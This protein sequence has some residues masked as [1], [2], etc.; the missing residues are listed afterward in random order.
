[1]RA[2]RYFSVKKDA[3]CEREEA[4]P[5]YSSSRTCQSRIVPYAAPRFSHAAQTAVEHAWESFVFYFGKDKNRY[6]ILLP[7]DNPFHQMGLLFGS[8]CWRILP[9][10]LE[11]NKNRLVTLLPQHNPL[12]RINNWQLGDG[13]LL[14]SRLDLILSTGSNSNRLGKCIREAI[15][16]YCAPKKDSN[17]LSIL[18]SIFPSWVSHHSR[19]PYF[20]SESLLSVFSNLARLL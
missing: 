8:Y 15:Y 17:S 14:N 16:S 3:F 20:P 5:K 2:S 18:F 11:R 1:M 13:N 4:W 10:L 19:W 12:Y 6:L 9:F 7:Q